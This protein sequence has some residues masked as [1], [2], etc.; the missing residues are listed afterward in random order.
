MPHLT[1]DD[2]V[3]LAIRLHAPPEDGEQA[4]PR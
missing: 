1:E 2:I 4:P 3:L